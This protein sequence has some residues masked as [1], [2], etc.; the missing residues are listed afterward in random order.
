MGWAKG[1]QYGTGRRTYVY[2][3]T[4][5]EKMSK[6][7]NRFLKLTELIENG[8]ATTQQKDA[9]ERIRPFVM[10]VM[11]KLHATKTENYIDGDLPILIQSTD[12]GKGKG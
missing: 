8:K 7:L 9:Y 10:K 12:Y 11:D 3:K 4:Q 1:N 6:L 5:L 2:E